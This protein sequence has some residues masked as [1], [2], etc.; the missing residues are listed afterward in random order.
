MNLDLT[1]YSEFI[2]CLSI[3]KDL[4]NDVD[5]REGIIRQK[6]NDGSVVFEVDLT[7][8]IGN[9]NMRISNLKEK[10]DILKIFSG[11]NVTIENTESNFKISDSYSFWEI[12]NPDFDFMDNKFIT[13]EELDGVI[14]TSNEDLLIRTSIISIITDR[15]RIMTQGFH[16]NNVQVVFNGS[17]ASITSK[18]VSKDQ[19]ANFINNITTEQELVCNTN[20]ISIP[21]TIDHDGDILFEMFKNDEDKV[22]NRFSTTISDINITLYSRGQL[23]FEEEKGEK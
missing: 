11:Q 23:V 2:R 10:L 15:I 22:L 17:E 1:R 16:V 19:F 4:C 18:T 5:I 20:I 21:F 9:L 14:N 8:A 7:Q 6:A 13:K 3:F 12:E